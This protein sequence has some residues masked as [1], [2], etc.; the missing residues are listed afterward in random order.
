MPGPPDSAGARRRRLASQPDVNHAAGFPTVPI[1]LRIV[2][3][4]L[5][6][7]LAH[8]AFFSP[9]QGVALY[10]AR[11]FHCR[12][13]VF[14]LGVF[15]TDGAPGQQSPPPQSGLSGVG[16]GGTTGAGCSNGGGAGTSGDG[17]LSIYGA[18]PLPEPCAWPQ[19]CCDRKR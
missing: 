10:L 14:C 1:V 9:V 5:A 18:S 3:P 15:W 17:L 4:L 6:I 2:F 13:I 8:A 11:I 12:S 19:P 16:D 7:V